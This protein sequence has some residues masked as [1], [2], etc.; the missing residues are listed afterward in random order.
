MAE[1]ISA[2]EATMGINSVCLDGEV[3][4]EIQAGINAD[5]HVVHTHLPDTISPKSAKVVW[6][7]HGTPEVMFQNSVTEGTRHIHGSPDYWMQAHHHIRTASA[8]VTF[9]ERHAWI[10]NGLS[11]RGTIVHTIPMGVNRALWNKAPSRGKF[12]GSPSILT[13]ENCY[14]CK[15]PLD[16]F[17]AMP[18]VFEQLPHARLHVFNLPQDQCPWWYPLIFDNGTAYRSYIAVTRFESPDLANAFASVDYYVGLVRYGDHNRMMLEAKACGRPV[19]SY[20]GNPYADYWV[21]EG[22]QRNIAAQLAMIL[23]GQVPPRETMP[24]PDITETAAAMSKIY[25]GI[26]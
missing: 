16:L 5:I 25:E 8:I 20:R 17:F 26:L 12:V 7:A 19:I 9:W 23:R 15:W 10:W 1:E 14:F 11:D 6:V 21:D 3:P 2:C 13:G 4:A 22:D 24:V 18:D